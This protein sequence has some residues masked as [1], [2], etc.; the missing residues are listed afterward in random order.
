MFKLPGD[1]PPDRC[2]YQGVR[3]PFQFPV[4]QKSQKTD[5]PN[6]SSLL[7]LKNTNFQNPRIS[8]NNFSLWEQLLIVANV[9]KPFLQKQLQM[10]SSVFQ[11]FLN[12]PLVLR[13]TDVFAAQVF[14]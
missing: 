3:A 6:L 14:P 7:S 2:S 1:R 13:Q 12:S 5:L 8:E 4:L 9:P 11:F 10:E